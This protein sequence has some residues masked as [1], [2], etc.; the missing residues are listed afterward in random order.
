MSGYTSI[1]EEVLQ[2]LNANMPE[3][4]ERFS[5][6]TLGIFGSVSR[7]EDTPES[8]V[9]ILYKFKDG[10]RVYQKFLE[11]SDY[12]ENLFGRHV[13]MV[14]YDWIDS[15]MKTAVLQESILIAPAKTGEA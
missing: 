11:L 14:A 15:Y 8:D 12:L 9:D 5:I 1:K 3:I 13:D 7:G 10:I 6:E 4:R 2:K